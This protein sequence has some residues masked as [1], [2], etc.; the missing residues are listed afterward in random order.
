LLA[1]NTWT[2]ER[3]TRP[4]KTD[5]GR[6]LELPAGDIH[7]REDGDPGDPPLLLIHGFGV[8]MR[9]FEP[10]VP[11][12]AREHRVIRVDLLGHGGSEKPRGSYSMERQADL[13][14]QVLDRLDVERAAVVG[15]SMG[16][17]V[18]TALIERHAERVSRLMTIGTPPDATPGR[19]GLGERLAFLPV[20]GHAIRRLAPEYMIRAQLEETLEPEVD[21]PERLAE[22]INRTTYYSFRETGEA[23]YNYR[24]DKPLD[25]RLA[26]EGVPLT[27]VFGRRE[28]VVDLDAV[29][30]FHDVPE[31]RLVLLDGLG[32][33]PQLEDPERTAQLILDF[34]RSSPTRGAPE[35]GG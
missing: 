26:G 4:A 13:V 22:D 2:V 21:L 14:A 29:D 10:V 11:A 18:A 35:R 7:V 12:L 31:A 6:I 27:I 28:K 30:R 23:N 33:S 1:V 20:T 15:H 17:I 3:E 24:K 32:H 25:E 9:W 19:F 34:A 8:S 16:G 5:G